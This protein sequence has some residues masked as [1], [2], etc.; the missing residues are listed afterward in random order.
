MGVRKKKDKMFKCKYCGRKFNS[1]HGLHVHI[2]HNHLEKRKVNC[3][4]CGKEIRICPF[5]MKRSKHHFCSRECYRKWRKEKI[6]TKQ[7]ERCGK[8]FKVPSKKNKR[9][10]SRECYDKWRSK[11]KRGENN[12]NWKGGENN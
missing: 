9:F 4:Y 5:Y 1:K 3:D 12:P 2:G 8:E 7:C 11:N 10:C 6:P